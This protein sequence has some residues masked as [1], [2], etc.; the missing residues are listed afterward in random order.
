MRSDAAT[1][2]AYYRTAFEHSQ[3]PL[4]SMLRELGGTVTGIRDRMSAFFTGRDHGG[5]TNDPVA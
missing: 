2:A 5:N 4:V 3:D 1:A